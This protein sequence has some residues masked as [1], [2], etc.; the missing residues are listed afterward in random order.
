MPNEEAQ[1]YKRFFKS[2]RFLHR[3]RELGE[4]SC[5]GQD[6]AGK[7]THPFEDYILGK[8][9]SKVKPKH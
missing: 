9:P 1:A 7:V 8:D 6:E 3:I 4:S 5:H 2:L